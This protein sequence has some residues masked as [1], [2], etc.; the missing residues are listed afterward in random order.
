MN[1][2]KILNFQNY[3][4]IECIH[5]GKKSLVYRAQHISD[6]KPVI[7]KLLRSEYPSFSE[8]V[9]FRHQYTIAQNLNLSG[10]VQPLALENYRNSLIL[11]MADEGYISLDEY[12]QDNSLNLS[13]CLTIGIQLAEILAELY[14]HR[15]IHKDIKPGNILIHPATFEIQV[16]DFSIAS[17]LPRET[18]VLKNPHILE[19]TL[20][21]ISPEQ[22]GRMNRGIDYRTD[23]Y[24]FGVT[25]Y[26][27]FSGKLPFETTDAMELVHCHIA[28][29]PPPLEMGRWGDGE[30]GR[31]EIP[32]TLSNIILK[33]MAKNAE[34]RYQSAWGIQKDL[35]T[36][37]EQLENTGRIELFEIGK[38]DICD[39]FIIPEKLYGRQQKVQE[40]LDAFERVAIPPQSPLGKGGGS[41]MILVAGYS[42]VGKTAVVNEVHK[43]I[44]RQRGYF[45]QGKFEQFQRNIPFSAFVQALRDLMGQLLS[46]NDTQLKQWKEQILAAVGENGQVIIKVIP[47]LEKIIGFQP[48]VA[49]LSGTAAQNRFNLLFQKF[50]QVFTTK[51]HPLVIFLDDLQWTDSASLNLI[52]LLISEAESQYLLLI[53]AYRDNEVS[54]A[55]PLMLTLDEI[56]KNQAIVNTITLAPLRQDDLNQLIADTLHCSLKQ[57]LPL[58]QAVDQ[59]TKGN[60]FFATQFLKALYEDK[61]IYFNP[62]EG[63]WQCDLALVKQAAVSEDVVEFVSKRLQKLNPLTQDVLKLAACIGN[64]FDLET[65]AIVRQ[66]TELETATDLWV[67][68]KEGLIIPTTEVYKFYTAETTEVNPIQGSQISASYKFLHDRIQQAAY[69]LIPENQKKETHFKIG[70]LLVKN[71][72]E[73]KR[74]ERIFEIVNQ[75]NYGVELIVEQ[76][77][78]DRLAELNLRAGNKAKNSTAYQAACNY[79]EIGI[80]LLGNE[81]WQRKYDITLNLHELAAEATSLCGEFQ[82]MNQWIEATTDNA[83]TLLEKIGVYRVK[84]QT[85]C[86]LM[87]LLEAITIGESILKEF[88][89]E[90][91]ENPT[92]EDIQQSVQEINTL[93][94]NRSIEEFFN[95]PKMIDVEQLAVM[96]IAASIFSACYMTGSPLFPFVV[97]LQVKLSIQYGNSPYS[98]FSYACYS[99]VLNNFFQEIT[100]GTEFGKLAYRLISESNAQKIRSETCTLLGL[101][102]LHRQSHLRETL[103][104]FQMGY[105]AGLETGQLEYA[106]YNAIGSCLN[107][108][109]SGLPLAGL[110]SQIHAFYQQ[111]L[112][113]NR[114]KMAKN[115]LVYWESVIFLLGNPDNIEF[116]LD[117]S[118]EEKAMVTEALEFNDLTQPFIF[119]I[120]RMLLRFLM[121]EITQANTDAIQAK[122]YVMGAASEICEA[123]LYFYDSLIALAMVSESQI[124][125]ETQLQRVQDN[126]TQLQFW[127]KH[128][129]M[130]HQHKVDL[131]E[132]EKHRILGNKLEA[133][134]L[135]DLAISGAKENEY[136]QEQALANELAAKFY[137]E[138]GRKKVAQTYMIDAYYCYSH[139]GAQAKIKDIEQRYPELLAPILEQ[140]KINLN[141]WKTIA[142]LGNTDS[143]T[144]ATINSNT[145]GVSDALDFTS[146][147]KASQALSSEI[148]LNQLISQLMQVMMENAGATKGVLILSQAEQLTVKAISHHNSNDDEAIC[149]TE[150][151]IP[152]AESL[153][154]PV[155]IINLVKR[156][157]ELLNLDEVSS[158]TQ[159]ASDDYFIQNQ[160]QSLLCLPLCSRGEFLGILYLENNLTT[161]VFTSERVEVLKL[162]CSQAA[163]SLEN[164]QLYQKSQDYAQ[165]LEQSLTKLQEAQVQLVQSEKMSAL[166]QMM[167]GITHEI[168]NPLGFVSGNISQVE[169]AIQDVLEHLEVYQQNHPPGETVTAHAE[170]IELEYV[171]EDL[172]EMIGSMQTG[173][174]RIAEISKS[175]RIFS[176]GDREQKVTFDLHEGID[177]TLLILKHRLKGNEFRPEINIIKDYGELPQI[178]GFPGQLNQVFMNIIANAIDVFDEMSE[179]R[180]MTQMKQHPYRIILTTKL[181]SVS[182]MVKISIQDNGCG[183]SEEVK[184]RIFNHLFTT[185]AVGKGTGLGLSIARQIVEEKHDGKLSCYSQLGKGTE[186]VIEIPIGM[187]LVNQTMN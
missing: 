142:S 37:L 171:L 154:V 25:L 96:Q 68:L 163:I 81:A 89:V 87:Q 7:L 12:T 133:M 61:L 129:P 136:I 149:C 79:G 1:D 85:L 165:Q 63:F 175:M 106:A 169:E 9:Q 156:S 121:G 15:I 166:G 101:F 5:Q 23:F 174:N 13:Q 83:K 177:S 72:P 53:G 55:H 126:Q 40:L 144:Q 185:K 160:P 51:D 32:Q 103:P 170:E 108:Y 112:E 20:A 65:L 92:G 76:K 50:L 130:N 97:A 102:V 18:Q 84:I 56:Q 69:S 82:Q 34:E 162:L 38:R 60:P 105:Q 33:L 66:T 180:S 182:Q 86:S 17:L 157:L 176:R 159:F 167:S 57:A 88:G 10:V 150:K 43:P 44:V 47:E 14:H 114:I 35:E 100:A 70:Q 151:S 123:G 54:P 73:S 107:G 30:M 98:A 127:A 178:L 118:D 145:T 59:K 139:W 143:Y 131:V 115:C 153:A 158:Q 155:S 164:A 183:M 8:L 109:W 111:L 91:P 11:V 94:G 181:D 28:K 16:I 122:P 138:L 6:N 36:C 41:E 45:I 58:T 128:A 80:N 173:V 22:T 48:A 93:I 26:E 75:L 132:A 27:L 67:A 113:F 161:G 31:E 49:E 152:V 2:N 62:E 110:E 124:E 3:Q 117:N 168:N 119:Y 4:T 95:L 137:L 186:F 46:E 134:E 116:S 141:P 135:Y 104:I 90:F 64:Q 78:R 21:Y 179:A 184:N 125:W 120:H 39:H 24:S 187:A 147:I 172:P 19:G 99:V 74:E 146:I 29:V 71:I 77:E 52:K 148:E 140:Q 42:G